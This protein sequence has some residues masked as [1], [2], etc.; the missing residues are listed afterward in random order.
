MGTKQSVLQ[1][2]ISLL[3]YKKTSRPKTFVLSE[4]DENK[5]MRARAKEQG[6]EDNQGANE[7]GQKQQGKREFAQGQPDKTGKTAGKTDSQETGPG[8]RRTLKK[9]L[10]SAQVRSRRNEGGVTADVD[11]NLREINQMFNSAENKDLI[12]RQFSL[13]GNIRCFLAYIDGMADK[14]I[15]DDYILRP[16]FSAEGLPLPGVGAGNIALEDIVETNDAKRLTDLKKV[17]SEILKGNT[18]VYINGLDYYLA[19]ES[20]GFEK[21][22]VTEPKTEGIV[23]GPQEA[24]SENVRTNISLVRRII[25]NSKLTTEFF[26]IGEKTNTIVAIIYLKDVVNPAIVKEV[27]RRLNNIETDFLVSSGMLEQLIEDNPYSLFPTILSTERPDRTASHIIEGRVAIIMD[28][29]PFA[30]L[31]PTAIHAFMHSPED[32]ALK[33]QY[34]TGL[35]LIRLFALI[36]ASMLPGLYIALTTF[37]REMIP[38]DLLIAIGKAKE[39]VPFP[40]IVEILLMELGF[41]LIREAG[42]RIPGIIGN[43]LG[44]IGALI[45]GDAAVSANIVSP[46]LI[47]IV[48]VTGLSNFAIPNYSLAFAVRLSRFYYI[49]AGAVLGFYGIAL[50]ILAY[51]LMLVNL[52]SFGIP[53]FSTI[54]PKTKRS[55]DVIIRWPL[56]MQEYRPDNINPLD[57]RRQPHI[58]RKWAEQDPD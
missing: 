19:C 55:R 4:I 22:T 36:A 17:V 46:I 12:I 5:E 20:M 34:T 49:V 2:I 14:K 8:T 7:Q 42:T 29:E 1:Q 13:R 15:I 37:H 11:A 23:R 47:I 18:A 52:K 24:F 51:I 6:Q 26:E 25:K 28:G 56:W 40:T 21:R 10:T 3:T 31:V 53:F 39:N 58:S 48:A 9:P 33:W 38:T 35:R 30:M 41:E 50:G 32:A 57:R 44:I 45:L 27:R 43:T 54:A 16:L